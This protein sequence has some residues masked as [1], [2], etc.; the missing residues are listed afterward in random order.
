VLALIIG[1]FATGNMPDRYRIV[2]EC[3]S[4]E[5]SISSLSKPIKLR[6]GGRAVYAFQFTFYMVRLAGYL[7]WG[8]HRGELDA[9]TLHVTEYLNTEE[10]TCQSNFQV[11]F[12][13]IAPDVNVSSS[14]ACSLTT[15]NDPNVIDQLTT[16]LISF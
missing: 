8:R 14:L 11:T 6:R 16:L 15:L 12:D 9:G 10:Q 5:V 1:A 3:V 4:F 13:L 7:P 2:Y